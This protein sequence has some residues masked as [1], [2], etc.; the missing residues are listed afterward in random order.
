MC[1]RT[2][3]RIVNRESKSFSNAD[4]AEHR[5]TRA[6]SASGGPPWYDGVAG[7]PAARPGPAGSGRRPPPPAVTVLRRPGT[8]LASV[9]LNT[10]FSR[11]VSPET[12]ECI[13]YLRAHPAS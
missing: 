5:H 6:A 3:V 2:R 11:C 10:A 4:R 12:L 9:I 1:Q 7:R 8:A 13:L